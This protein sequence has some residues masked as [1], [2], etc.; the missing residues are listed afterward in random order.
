MKDEH[1]REAAL[2][3][4]VVTASG[5]SLFGVASA[6]WGVVAGALALWMVLS[7]LMTAAAVALMTAVTPPDCAYSRFPAG[8]VEDFPVGMGIPG[9]APVCGKLTAIFPGG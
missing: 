1:T 4:F 7:V 3:T 6:F 2:I 9:F 8:G 5:L